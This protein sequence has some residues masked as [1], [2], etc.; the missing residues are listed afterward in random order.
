[1][2]NSGLERVVS[3]RHIS[4]LARLLRNSTASERVAPGNKRLSTS[5]FERFL[6]ESLMGYAIIFWFYTQHDLWKIGLLTLAAWPTSPDS[7]WVRERQT[8]DS[9]IVSSRPYSCLQL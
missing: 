2:V 4:K 1:M 6:L 9:S 5:A 8:T 7:E 3:Q